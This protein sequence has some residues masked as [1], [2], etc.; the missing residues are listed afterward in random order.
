MIIRSVPASSLFR[1]WIS[2]IPS[3][4]L[5]YPQWHVQCRMFEDCAI[6]LQNPTVKW[7]SLGEDIAVGRNSMTVSQNMVSPP[8]PMSQNTTAD[9][10]TLWAIHATVGR[11][12]MRLSIGEIQLG[13]KGLL[14][15]MQSLAKLCLLAKEI[16]Y[17][18]HLA[19]YFL[20][21]QW[22]QP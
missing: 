5:H 13:N 7:W 15:E 22:R 12:V 16:W 19:L 1:S 21:W 6:V 14:L 10:C 11:A 9:P 2:P 20:A 17:I 18:G 3:L 8:G 4:S